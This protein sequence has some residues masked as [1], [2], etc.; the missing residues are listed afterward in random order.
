MT[1]NYFTMLVQETIVPQSTPVAVGIITLNTSSIGGTE[2]S[3]DHL[4]T[5]RCAG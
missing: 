2:S 1:P 4:A 3:R 5:T